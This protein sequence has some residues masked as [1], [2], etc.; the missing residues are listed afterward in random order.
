LGR[1]V[2]FV[3]VSVLPSAAQQIQSRCPRTRQRYW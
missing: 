1:S 2:N 3:P